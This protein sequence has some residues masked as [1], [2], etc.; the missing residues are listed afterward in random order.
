MVVHWQF[1]K[2]AFESDGL[3]VREI[4][5]SALG[6]VDFVSSSYS[7]EKVI[8]YQ[9]DFKGIVWVVHLIIWYGVLLGVMYLRTLTVTRD[10]IG[11]TYLRFL[12][13]HLEHTHHHYP[14]SQR[15]HHYDDSAPCNSVPSCI[16]LSVCGSVWIT[17][18]PVQIRCITAYHWREDA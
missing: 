4:V 3:G 2:K 5:L 14:T 15:S 18:T 13:H 16:R 11:F 9:I 12:P 10:V 6:N 17:G 7:T 8:M 1:I